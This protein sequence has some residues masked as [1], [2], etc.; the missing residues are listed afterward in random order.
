M[1]KTR[2]LEEKEKKKKNEKITTVSGK[3]RCD[4]LQ[5]WVLT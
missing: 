3:N 2:Y 5:T 4:L 1:F